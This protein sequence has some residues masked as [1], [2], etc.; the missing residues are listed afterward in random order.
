[1][2]LREDVPLVERERELDAL[3]RML[4]AARDGAGAAVLVEGEAGI[5]K[6]QLLTAARSAASGFEVLT[7]RASELERDF[8]FG[9]VR[10]LLEPPLATAA[11]ADRTELLSGAAALA[12]RVLAPEAAGQAV[13]GDPS[14]GALH[15]LYWLVANLAAR[16]PVLAL[17]DD[18]HWADLPS[19][20]WL[21]YLAKRL[22]G[23]ALAL[24]VAARQREPGAPSDFLNA[25]AADPGVELLRPGGLSLEAVARLAE[26]ALGTPADDGFAATFHRVTGGNPFLVSQ[27]LRELAR[28]GVPPTASHVDDVMRLGSRGVQRALA[29]RLGVLGE[30]PASLAAAV[31]MLGD[32]T[33]LGLAAR[34][35][36]LSARHA[37]AAAE[38][39]AAVGIL[40]GS[41]SLAFVHPLVRASVRSELSEAERDAGHA[42][43][44]ELLAEAGA[45][46]DRIAVHLLACGPRGDPDVVARL[47][48]A[49]RGAL[50]R[51]AIEVAVA[52]LRR[53]LR[54]PPPAA[55]T[56][57]VTAE[58][59]SAELQAGD[60][61]AAVSD[62]AAA[63]AHLAEP[64]VRAR[65][66]A[67]LA[68]ALAFAGRPEQAVQ[69]LNDALAGLPDEERELGLLLQGVRCMAAHGSPA[70]WRATY[71]GGARFDA[72]ADRPA[73]PGERLRV[74]E[75]AVEA[76]VLR[77]AG[78]ARDLALVALAGG[79]PL[80]DQ[81]PIASGA[82]SIAPSVL[83][84][85][86]ALEEAVQAYA[87]VIEWARRHGSVTVFSAA[88]HLRAYTWWRR[89]A[90]GEVE[91][92]TQQARA[93]VTY[94]GIPY[95]P[96][97]L[98]EALLARGDVS[99]AERTW[100]EAELDADPGESI[101]A[102]LR[103]HA[104]GHL[105]LAAG[106]PHEALADFRECGRRERT[107][108]LQTPC[109]TTWR[110]D[111]ARVLASLDRTEEARELC[112]EELERCRAFGSA[113]SLGIALR[114]AARVERGDRALPLLEEAL[115]VLADSPARL[116][117]ALALFD[118]GAELRRSG[119]RAD[120]RDPLRAAVE[121][122]AECGADSL[123]TRAHD[124]LLA[125]GARPRRDPI[126]S[127]SRLTA[128]ELRVARMA[129]EGMSNREIA[130][131][132]FL[133]EKTIEV[134][135]TRTYRK[136]DIRSR[137]QLGRALPAAQAGTATPH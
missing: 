104:R 56:P 131:A 19:L 6:S 2:R 134:H 65:T 86:D 24:V 135:L 60:L 36:G 111:A 72:P 79:H 20:R 44:A 128:S 122:A 99:A 4:D 32:D 23:L 73:T 28:A 21:L 26:V 92:D 130:Q 7:A 18:L 123:A 129:A 25:L 118:L 61:D 116:E 38:A 68:T 91:A 37:L 126:E 88:S 41:R 70:A 11:G 58:L 47:R 43:A 127:R 13:A 125:A 46:A 57:A 108:G 64:R 62:L 51:G 78:E 1:M 105:R 107:W 31:A 97:A 83:M 112:A 69:A 39:L 94:F 45:P 90:L 27:A 5:G 54:E 33:E 110:S 3:G 109:L 103:F 75:R 106:R 76:M 113:R 95:G 52:Y 42:R 71:A 132:L 82:W 17:V 136:L 10:Q 35:A 9:L 15:G 102:D 63:A 81:G 22:D 8:P 55:E 34:L 98:V 12:E 53:A 117:H 101:G 93:R 67:E 120:A 133:T 137:S 14:F 48:E 77:R 121:L 16:R 59:G 100:R 50:A 80:A 115:A 29:A 87:E 40:Q 84:F 124:E 49:A 66:A 119:R 85:C 74:A 89:G 114:A 30:G 96:L